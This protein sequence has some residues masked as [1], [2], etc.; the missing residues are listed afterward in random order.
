MWGTKYK[1]GPSDKGKTNWHS[2]GS[3]TAVMFVA[4]SY[5]STPVDTGLTKAELPHWKNRPAGTPVV[6]RRTRQ[7][8]H[9]T[10]TPPT[11]AEHCK[12]QVPGGRG[13]HAVFTWSLGHSTQWGRHRASLQASK[14]EIWSYNDHLTLKRSVCKV[15]FQ[16]IPGLVT[17][18][19][20][21]GLGKPQ[22]TALTH[23]QNF[24]LCAEWPITF[25]LNV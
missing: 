2:L 15:S 18:Q 9:T 3:S 19:L 7:T 11:A 21:S 1:A 12:F 4:A 14:K 20:H 24:L 13:C 16:L 23:K 10:R 6:Q 17:H 5:Q 8:R 22:G 25:N